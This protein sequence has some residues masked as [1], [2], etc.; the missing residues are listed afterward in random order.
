MTGVLGP[1]IGT[2]WGAGTGWEARVGETFS[3]RRDVPTVSLRISGTGD[4]VR[5]GALEGEMGKGELAKGDPTPP[6]G[7]PFT[8]G[9]D[10]E[11]VP[12]FACPLMLSL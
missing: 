5:D 11:D 7:L 3:G 2:G 12:L 8:R 4:K 9:E 6:E 1:G 10:G